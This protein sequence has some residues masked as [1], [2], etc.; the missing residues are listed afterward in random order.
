MRLLM[1]T[2]SLPYPLH[3]GGAIRNF[4]ILRGLHDTGHEVT[5]LSFHD[6]TTS[7]EATPL[8]D[9]CVNVY[10]VP[11][12]PRTKLARLRDLLLTRQP[13]LARRLYSPDFDGCLRSVLHSVEFDLVQF[14]GFEMAAYLSTVRQVQPSAKLC[15]DAHNA[16][17]VL[18]W[19][20][21]EVDRQDIW[22]WPSAVYSFIQS[23]RIARVEAELCAN[24]NCVIAVSDEDANAL[25]TLSPATRIHVVPNG[26]DADDYEDSRE[27]LD[28]GDNVLV[29]TGKMDYRP[30][31]DAVRWFTTAILPEVQK[32]VP[33]AYL[34][35]VGQKPHAWVETLRDKRNVAITGWVNDV[36]PYLQAA[37]VYVA[38][39]RM[40]SGTR[41][42]ILEAMAA[43]CAVVATSY[44]ASGLS[45]E[46]RSVMVVADEEAELANAIV[47]LLRSSQSREALGK[48]SRA[49]VKQNYD[50]PVL[51][52]KLLAAYRE[53]GLG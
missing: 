29:F 50:W 30:N 7:V 6:G 13:D 26:V 31:V 45:E 52:P 10:T 28:L 14:E 19:A 11:V 23:G 15:Y 25:R 21:Y 36:R 46:A 8:A 5:L 35:I 34:Y 49:Y 1:L 20:I 51:L 33:D 39:L 40:G 32:R 2:P 44:A 18:Q 17:Y 3:Q 37:K 9:L 22:R 24:V 38:H 42:K 43:G 41:L 16:E 53:I 48:A 4:G 27:Q 47:S 12:P